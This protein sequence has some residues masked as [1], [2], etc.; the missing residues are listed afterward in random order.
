MSEGS[1]IGRRVGDAVITGSGRIGLLVQ[2]TPT[3]RA[4]VQFVENGP[5]RY[6]DAASLRRAT[7]SEI[8]HSHMHELGCNQSAEL[9]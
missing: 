4:V 7:L 9:G 5:R 3:R 1:R 2:F 8:W 6:I